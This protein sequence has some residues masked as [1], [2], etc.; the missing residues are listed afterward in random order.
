MIVFDDVFGDEMKERM[1]IDKNE[2]MMTT[3]NNLCNTM[4]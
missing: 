3:I 1:A 2:E 4:V